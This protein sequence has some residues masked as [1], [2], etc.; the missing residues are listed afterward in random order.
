MT[1]TAIRATAATTPAAD[2]WRSALRDWESAALMADKSPSTAY[3]YARHVSWLAGDMAATCP[4]PWDLSPVALEEWLDRQGWSVHTRRKV[5]VS[6]RAFYTWGI[7]EGHCQRSPL[8]GLAA[9]PRRAPGPRRTPVPPRWQRAVDEWLTSLRATSASEGSIEN[10]RTR[11]VALA[12][13]YADPWRVTTTDLERYLARDDWAP[14]TKRGARSVARTF[15]SWAVRA[16]HTQHNPAEPL[17]P[18]RVPRS[19]P[20][21]APDSAVAIALAAADDRT[22]LALLIAAYAGLRRAE[23]ARIHTRDISEDWTTLRVHGKG[24]H[25]RLVPLHPHLVDL[26][27]SELR[28][29]RLGGPLRPGWG[30]IVPAPEGW[31]FPTTQSAYTHTGHLSADRIGDLITDAL[32]PGWT[33]HTLRHRFATQAYEVGRDLRAV[34]ELLGHAKPETTARYAAVP[35]GALRAAVLGLGPIAP[36]SQLV[37]AGSRWEAGE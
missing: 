11:I 20:R 28:R 4:E 17:A 24:G 26:L 16:G 3:E 5:L 19:M 36:V 10:R 8:A 31:L 9:A 33:T 22:R 30:P 29:R 32:P 13:T 6:L 21:P 7:Y 15:Y 37:D 1:T 23:I 2:A 34:Q 18:V 25:E 35:T 12:E 14:E 27:R